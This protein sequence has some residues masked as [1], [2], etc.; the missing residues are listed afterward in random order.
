MTSAAPSRKAS[1]RSRECSW[2]RCETMT[3]FERAAQPEPSQRVEPRELGHLDV[4]Q[5]G[6]RLVLAHLVERDATVLGDVDHAEIGI[7]GHDLA[8]QAPHHR[9]V[10]DHEH[11]LLRRAALEAHRDTSPE[12]RGDAREQRREPPPAILAP[13]HRRDHVELDAEVEPAAPVAHDLVAERPQPRGEDRGADQVA[14]AAVDDLLHR[15]DEEGGLAGAV[16]RAPAERHAALDGRRIGDAEQPPEVDHQLA[17][18]PVIVGGRSRAPGRVERGAA[19]AT[20][21]G[22]GSMSPTFSAGKSRACSPQ[23][24]TTCSAIKPPP[25]R[26][27]SRACAGRRR[28]A[29]A[30]DRRAPRDRPPR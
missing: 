13:A 11:G 23:R 22:P 8:E 6:V 27:A 12:R 20:R 15:V 2:A 3:T 18:S 16:G 4:E 14:G 21:A 5:H 10:V 26:G 17:R 1:A 7:G 29:G 30:P 24:T 9:A 25:R 28:L 19:R